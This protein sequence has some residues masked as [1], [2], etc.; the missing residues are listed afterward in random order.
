MADEAAPQQYRMS[1]AVSDIG[2]L[3]LLDS[4]LRDEKLDP[5]E[6]KVSERLASCVSFFSF[7]VCAVCDPVLVD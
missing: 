1:R 6:A 4:T 5:Q 2:R 3:R 7:V